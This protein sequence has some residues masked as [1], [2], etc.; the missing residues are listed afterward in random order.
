MLHLVTCVVPVANCVQAREDLFFKNFELHQADEDANNPEDNAM[1]PNAPRMGP[2]GPMQGMMP[3]MAFPMPMQ[4]RLCAV[5]AA[6]STSVAQITR[7]SS[8]MC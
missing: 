1:D 3:P 5:E 4:V 8:T 2:G 7:E 6:Q